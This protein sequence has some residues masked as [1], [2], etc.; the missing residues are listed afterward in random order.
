MFFRI[1]LTFSII[2]LATSFSLLV[3]GILI[4]KSFIFSIKILGNNFLYVPNDLIK[5]YENSNELN[6]PNK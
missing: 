3:I 5:K 1:D 2:F 6:S 4:G